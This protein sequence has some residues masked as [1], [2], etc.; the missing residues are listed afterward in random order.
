M[1]CYD[2]AVGE[3]RRER[4]SSTSSLMQIKMTVNSYIF[5]IV[6]EKLVALYF[7]GQIVVTYC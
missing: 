7:M 1:L 4:L 2:H 5:E 3:S 6:V